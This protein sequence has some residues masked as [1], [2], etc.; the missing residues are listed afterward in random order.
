VPIAPGTRLGPYQ[1][2]SALG[3]GG[4]GEVYRARDGKLN[5]D[6]ALKVLPQA[7]AQDTER[8]ARFEREAQVL[9]ALND[10][11]IASIY[12]LEDSSGTP[13]LVMELVEGPSLADRLAEGPIPVPEA[14]QLAKQIADALDY[15]HQ[16]GIIHR[17]L[18]PANIKITPDGRVKIL[19]FGLAKAFETGAATQ[20]SASGV[21]R[22]PTLTLAATQEGVI[23]G[24]AAYMSPEQARGHQA[25]KRS[26]I[27]SFGVVLFEML[28][29]KQEFAGDTVSDS[30][31]AVLRAEVEWSALPADLPA[32]ARR[33][34]RRCLERDRKRRLADIADARLELEEALAGSSEPVATAVAPP[35]GRA[36]SR[37]W[38][39]LAALFALMAIALASVHFREKPPEWEVIRFQ[40]PAPEKASFAPGGMAL[41]PDGHRLAFVATEP[42]GR[43]SL[44]VRPLDSVAA[45]PLPGT[46]NASAPFWS[47]DS[48]SIGFFIPGKL[49]RIDAAGG[50]P[51]TVCDVPGTGVGAS[52]NRDGVIV[53]ASNSTG[54]F[55]VSQAGGT[56]TPLT[57][58]DAS[59]RET[60]HA[61][62]W[63]L[64][65]GRHFIYCARSR[66]AENEGIYLTTLE[67]R[68]RKRLVVAREAAAYAPPSGGSEKGHVL[69]LRDGTL[70]AQALDAG[71][72]EPSGEPFFVADQVGYVI[73]NAFFS[74]SAT[75]VLAYR[76]GSGVNT[77]LTWFDREGKRLETV[78]PPGF[79][80][81]IQLAPDG[82][83][84]AVGKQDAQTGNRDLWLV[85]VEHGVP[86]RFT[87]DPAVDANPVWSPDG[88]RV[89]FNS[90]RDGVSN[91]FQ[92]DAGGGR[93]E[94][95]LLKS[96][97]EKRALDY[98]A[99]GRFLLYGVFDPQ[100]FSDIWVLPLEGERK[101][102]PFLNSRFGESQGQFS[103]GP[104]GAPR[105]VAYTSDESD[106]N[107]VYVQAFSGGP[108]GAS[109]KFQISS[110]GGG[111]PRWRSDGQELYYLSLDSRL[112]AVEIKTSPQFQHGVPRPLFTTRIVEGGSALRVAARYSP[113]PDGKRFL[114]SSQPEETASAPTTVV[115]NW[116]AGLKR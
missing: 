93:N 41:S 11:N 70:M 8:M 62:P 37:W 69:F 106:R 20:S 27:W 2:L 91:L 64:P 6:V 39:A 33:L 87:F 98:S 48:R 3:A 112:M 73:T 58:L 72:F 92:K 51:Q 15:A 104:A 102:F 63:F 65:D 1:V 25:D 84:V 57:A 23:L 12:G 115:L 13:A 79:Y 50:P 75:G 76:S 78:G 32:P 85:D 16:R 61:R 86:T 46:D 18:K 56:V 60:Y 45:Q 111:Q 95:L 74:V 36:A 66:Q 103:P 59:K 67:G 43:T 54:L 99:D 89:V 21:S 28:T 114:I 82:K 7:F 47:T 109:G 71:S 22:S 34:L 68:D 77:H 110:Q 113:S 88:G 24:T 14:L 30:L 116:T 10:P 96:D 26:D 29:A 31:A 42:D 80:V 38:G 35:R 81:E 108:A 94:E 17:D 19:D 5:R 4:M 97:L 105:W 52:W 83:K 100:T 90:T 44:W 107:E 9:A 40:I 49:K 55:R 101:P 53:F